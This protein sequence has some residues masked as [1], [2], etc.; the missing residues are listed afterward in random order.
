MFHGD[1]HNIRTMTYIDH[2]RVFG[3]AGVPEERIKRMGAEDNFWASGATGPCGPC[4][5]LYYDL[6]P[7]RGM[8]VEIDLDDDSRFIEFYNLVFMELNRGASG[9]LTPLANKNIDTGMGLER[10]AQILQGVPNNYETDLIKPIM[11][12]AADLAGAL[13]YQP[14]I[15]IWLSVFW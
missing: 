4:S 5:E 11:D 15:G 10:M 13:L 1:Q 6:H 7:E 12:V 2:N 3:N 9:E 14:T 8:D